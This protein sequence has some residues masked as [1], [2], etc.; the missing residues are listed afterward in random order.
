MRTD[1]LQPTDRGHAQATARQMEALHVGWLRCFM[2][3]MLIQLEL[4]GRERQC[5]A[6]E[7]DV[8]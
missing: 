7:N 6:H 8:A 2:S 3:I 4:N 5:D 1:E